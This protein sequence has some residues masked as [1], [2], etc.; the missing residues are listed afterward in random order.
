MHEDVT[1]LVLPLEKNPTQQ[2]RRGYI[3]ENVQ[4]EVV[5]TIIQS[6]VEGSQEV[7]RG[8]HLENQE[9][10]SWRGGIQAA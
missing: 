8:R 7:A 10:A 3:N 5:N 1:E 2:R 9:P 6:S 4:E